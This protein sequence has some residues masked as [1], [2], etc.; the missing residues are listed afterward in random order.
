MTAPLGE[1]TTPIRRGKKGRGRLRSGANSPSAASLRFSS[2]KASASRP[3]PAGSSADH[4]DLELAPALVDR[5]APPAAHQL[6]VGDGAFSRLASR[7]NITQS[8]CASPSLR[9]K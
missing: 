4:R 9:Q 7:E 2:S 3:A 8:I 6:A 1:V 5:E